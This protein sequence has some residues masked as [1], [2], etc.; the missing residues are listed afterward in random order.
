MGRSQWRVGVGCGVVGVG[1]EAGEM[2]GTFESDV[3][4]GGWDWEEGRKQ[5]MVTESGMLAR[6]GGT[7]RSQRP[8]RVVLRVE[9]TRSRRESRAPS[10]WSWTRVKMSSA[11]WVPIAG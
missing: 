8:K 9:R 7:V 10:F 11:R 6:L 3:L 1:V 5:L 2:T 4:V